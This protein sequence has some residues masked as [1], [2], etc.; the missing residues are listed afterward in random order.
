MA[1]HSTRER[2]TDGSPTAGHSS[3]EGRRTIGPRRMALSE[4]TIAA[5][6]RARHQRLSPRLASSTSSCAQTAAS[7]SAA[8]PISAI[9]NGRITKGS[10]RNT[11]HYVVL[12]A[13]STRSPTRLGPPHESAKLNSSTGPTPRR[14]PCSYSHHALRRSADVLRRS[15]RAAQSLKI[16]RICLKSASVVSIWMWW[17]LP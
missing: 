15:H 13:W 8:L 12:F 10:A 5:H 14:K 6:R 3:R 16:P 17:R 7:T 11:P 2:G 9:A 1:S 4:R